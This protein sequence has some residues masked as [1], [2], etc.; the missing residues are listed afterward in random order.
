M[1][2]FTVLTI[3][4]YLIAL[5]ELKKIHTHTYKMAQQQKVSD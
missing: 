5:I 3:V 2:M 1:H 4:T